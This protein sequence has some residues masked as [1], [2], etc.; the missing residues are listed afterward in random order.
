MKFLELLGISVLVLVT[1][2]ILVNIQVIKNFPQSKISIIFAMVVML[3]F[4]LGTSIVRMLGKW[5][6]DWLS[7]L[8]VMLFVTGGCVI[9]FAPVYFTVAIDL[10]VSFWHKVV[11]YTLPAV[12]IE[13]GIF[14]MFTVLMENGTHDNLFI[15]EKRLLSVAFLGY[16]VF[17]VTFNFLVLNGIFLPEEHVFWSQIVYVIIS[18]ITVNIIYKKLQYEEY[19][20]VT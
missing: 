12:M 10:P 9:Y 8:G 14:T 3:V 18:A 20:K 7:I 17:T 15:R 11:W 6:Y 5:N 19:L 13:G 16:A 1:S 4:L 2:A